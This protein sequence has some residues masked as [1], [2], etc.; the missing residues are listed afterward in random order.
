M[1]THLLV[2]AESIVKLLDRLCYTAAALGGGG[3]G[4]GK[5]WW[6]KGSIVEV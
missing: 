1:N 5:G 4:A 6:R 3:E 2:M